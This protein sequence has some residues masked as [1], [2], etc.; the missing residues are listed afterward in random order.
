MH[1]GRSTPDVRRG[2]MED[3]AVLRCHV[4][5]NAATLVQMRVYIVVVNYLDIVVAVEELTFG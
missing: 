2:V 3:V 5:C 4:A 1:G